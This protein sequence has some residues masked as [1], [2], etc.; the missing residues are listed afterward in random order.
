MHLLSH[1]NRTEVTLW[2]ESAPQR[3]PFTPSTKKPWWILAFLRDALGLGLG[4][5]C[6][7]RA[8][9]LIFELP[10]HFSL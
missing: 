5:P 2:R 8:A 10:P 6:S 4:L 1:V 7:N 9:P 3:L